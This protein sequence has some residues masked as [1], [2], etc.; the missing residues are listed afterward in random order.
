MSNQTKPEIATIVALGRDGNHNH[1]LGKDNKLI[2]HIKEDLK[3]FKELSLGHPVIM[4][5]KTFESIFAML[6]KP[7]PNRTNIVV[8]RNADWHCEGVTTVSSFQEALSL[9]KQLD[10]ERIVIGGGAEIYRQAL[11]FTTKLYLTLIDDSKEADSFFPPYE[12]QFPKKIFEEEHQTPE[13]IRYKWVDVE[14]A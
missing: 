2:W 14:R 1:A 10:Q 6:G 9:A 5:R 13:G 11:P 12:D 3:R 4:G 7:L 8:T